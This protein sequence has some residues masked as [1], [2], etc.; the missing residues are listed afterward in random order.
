[1]DATVVFITVWYA[2]TFVNFCHGLKGVVLNMWHEIFPPNFINPIFVSH[3][4]FSKLADILDE[5]NWAEWQSVAFHSDWVI[6]ALPEE[7]TLKGHC[8]GLTYLALRDIT[9]HTG[10]AGHADEYSIVG[11]SICLWAIMW[12]ENKKIANC[13]GETNPVDSQS[14]PVH[15]DLDWIWLRSWSA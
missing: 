2:L 4:N 10:S 8:P 13:N 3:I 11:L 7:A 15:L 5:V 12:S 1:M 9:S 6:P 14:N